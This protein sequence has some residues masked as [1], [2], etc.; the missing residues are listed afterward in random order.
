MYTCSLTVMFDCFKY[1]AGLICNYSL[2]SALSEAL[3]IV[4]KLKIIRNMGLL[5]KK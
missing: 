5:I 3:P 2:V 1:T 4:C